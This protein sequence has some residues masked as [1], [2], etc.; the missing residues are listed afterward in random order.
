MERE[1]VSSYLGGGSPDKLKNILIN[2]VYTSVP[3]DPKMSGIDTTM[4]DKAKKIA[5]KIADIDTKM[6]NNAKKMAYNMK[7]MDQYHQDQEPPSMQY[8]ET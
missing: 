2:D 7:K 1:G 4:T 5:K 6:A 8:G 3:I